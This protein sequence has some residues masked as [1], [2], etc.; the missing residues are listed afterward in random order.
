M[1]VPRL[2]NDVWAEVFAYCTDLR[3]V[4]RA[5]IAFCLVKRG[6]SALDPLWMMVLEKRFLSHTTLFLS[7]T[8]Y[9]TSDAEKQGLAFYGRLHRRKKCGRSGCYAMFLE[10]DNTAASC[11]FHPG[12][13]NAARV[14]SC[15][16][17]KS[18]KSDGCRTGYHSGDFYEFCFST[19]EPSAPAAIDVTAATT[20]T[21]AAAATADA[22][23]ANASAGASITID[24]AATTTPTVLPAE[25]VDDLPTASTTKRPSL[26][27]PALVAPPAA[28]RGESALPQGLSMEQTK[29]P[30][31]R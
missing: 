10:I 16:R 18:F 25:D 11:R 9:P 3:E 12:K 2:S 27:L 21:A 17:Q 29:F 19:R 1:S 15:C 4:V 28:A 23:S 6:V 14:L 26:T 30:P 5:W 7:R 20:T 24:T 8:A 22:V 13:M 31:I